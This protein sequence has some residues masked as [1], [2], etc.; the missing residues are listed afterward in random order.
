MDILVIPDTQV[1][2]GVNTDHIKAAGN[3]ALKNKPDYIVVMGDWWDTESLSVYNSNMAKEG[4]RL[5]ND[6]ETGN[7][8]M[9]D[10]LAPINEYNIKR[11]SQK[12]KGYKPKL[13]FIEGNHD[14]RV[15]I[16]RLL[17][18]Y[19][20]LEGMLNDPTVPFLEEHGF[21]VIPFLH[22]HD[23]EGIKFSHY[24]A[25]PHS[26]K[27]SPLSGA[28]DTMLKNAGH[29]FVMGHQQTLK[30]GKHYL[31]DGSSRIGIVAGSFYSHEEGYMSKQS[32]NHFRGMVHLHDVYE[33]DADLETISIN[34]LMDEYG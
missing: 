9:I 20:A 24:I 30:M 31:S 27:G 7:Q 8:A 22:V 6:V 1:K 32:N 2:F 16:N 13:V 12:K 19:P 28:I 3:Y 18:D 25:N 14:V 23:I 15:R 21:E 4:L 29:S 33:G 10:F 17:E 11:K 26:L 34:R 5:L